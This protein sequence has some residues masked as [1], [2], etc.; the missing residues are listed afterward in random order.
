MRFLL[1]NDDGIGGPGLELLS[2]V[3]AELGEVVDVDG[4]LVA[5]EGG[6]DA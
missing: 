1:T 2:A 4:F 5:V 6:L 3:A